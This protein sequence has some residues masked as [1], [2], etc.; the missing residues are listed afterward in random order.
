MTT[1]GKVIRRY[2]FNGCQSCKLKP[3]CTTGK[4]R[5]VSRW[6]HEAVLDRVENRMD[7]NPLIMRVRKSTVEHPFG[8]LKAWMGATHFQMKTLE[9]VSGEMSLHILAY[10]L[11]RMMRIMGVLPL[12]AAMRA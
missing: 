1:K 9:R 4:E 11:K 7:N 10:N 3:Q 2:W 5:R 12:M 6:I 8:T